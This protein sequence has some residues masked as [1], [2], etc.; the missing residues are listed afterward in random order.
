MLAPR[1]GNRRWAG[2]AAVRTETTED[3]A[4]D[5]AVHGLA[6]DVT[7]NRATRADQRTRDDQQIVAQHEPAADAVHPE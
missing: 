1:A 6:H 7:E 4:H 2:A 3:N 5:G